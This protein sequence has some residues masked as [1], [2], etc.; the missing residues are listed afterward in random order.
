MQTSRQEPRQR[1][2]HR[3]TA[4][5]CSSRVDGWRS[6]SPATSVVRITLQAAAAVYTTDGRHAADGRSTRMVN[7]DAWA[8][9]TV[10]VQCEECSVWHKIRDEAHLIE[11]VSG[12]GATSLSSDNSGDEASNREP[13]ST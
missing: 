8:R 11:E 1:Q 7:P 13:P 2:V 9:G 12:P 5:S 6:P 3:P 4:C 10:F